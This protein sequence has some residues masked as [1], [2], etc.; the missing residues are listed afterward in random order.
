[1]AW[2][3]A[4]CRRESHPAGSPSRPQRASTSARIVSASTS[5]SSAAM[6]WTRVPMVAAPTLGPSPP[7]VDSSQ[8]RLQ[9]AKPSIR[10]GDTDTVAPS[11]RSGRSSLSTVRAHQEAGSAP[12]TPSAASRARSCAAA[13]RSAGDSWL[14]TSRRSS[15]DQGRQ[16]H[17]PV[18]VVEPAQLVGGVALV[19][20]VDDVEVDRG[21]LVVAAHGRDEQPLAG[22]ADR[23]E[24]QPGLVVADGRLGRPQ[25]LAAAGHDVDQPLG[26]QQ[27]AAQPQVGPDAL[28]DAGHDHE[29][30]RAAGGRLRGQQGHRV[31][32]GRPRHEGVAGHVLA[33]DVVEEP[34]AG[35]SGAAGRRSAR[36][37]RTAPTTASR[38]RSARP[39]RGRRPGRRRARSAPAR[40]PP[41]SPTAPS[42]P[43]RPAPS[44]PRRPRRPCGRPRPRPRSPAR[45]ASPAR[46]RGPRWPGSRG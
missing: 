8:R 4:S 37:R 43:S 31:V 25:G 33:A 38:S 35:P 16:G 18:D 1:M 11:G 23:D 45:R 22:P 24:E 5:P 7:H 42:R 13:S 30:P 12:G 44:G 3:S 40:S 2:A 41:T 34:V 9:S 36:R 6:S 29:R 27:R 14:T 46:P 39:P 17:G 10:E 19:G 21:L 28:L 15:A 32:A 26:A 20:R